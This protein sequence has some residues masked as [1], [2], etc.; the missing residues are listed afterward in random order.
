MDIKELSLVNFRNYD[1]LDITFDQKINIF[2]GNN[3]QGKTSLLES[4]Y[5]L[6]ISKSH[7]T[8][9]DKELIKFDQEFTKVSA[10]L[11]DDDDFKRLNLILSRSGKKALINNVEKTKMSDYIGAFN[12]VMFAPE[13]LNIVKGSPQ[14]RRKFI[15]VEIGQ[16]SPIYISELNT[17]N[18]ILRQRNELLKQMD[19]RTKQDTSFL[20]VLTEQLS[21]VAYKIIIRRIDFIK[22]LNHYANNLHRFISGHKEEL[23]INYQCSIKYDDS[24]DLSR[25]SIYKQYT[26]K[27]Q[28]DLYKGTT[29]LGPHRDDLLFSVNNLDVS[30]FGS[31]GQQRTTALSTKLSLIDFIKDETGKFPIV[32]LDDVLSELDDLRQTQLLDCIKEKVQTFVTTTN[33]SGIKSDLLDKSSIFYI[34][35]SNIFVK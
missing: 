9:K 16:I 35:N 8:H 21:D 23:I 31:Q 13:D 15:D 27:Y 25:E 29:S 10:K 28:S 18:K 12:V 34:E 20:D 30:S 11:L 4:I 1:R 33:I 3:A 26:D 22:K 5:F 2:I 32:L 7:K 24:H 19:Y 6:A 14:V 17:Y